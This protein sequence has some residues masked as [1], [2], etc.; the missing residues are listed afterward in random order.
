MTTSTLAFRRCL[1]SNHRELA[2]RRIKNQL[3]IHLDDEVV[4]HGRATLADEEDAQ[5]RVYV[6]RPI[7]SRRPG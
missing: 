5:K 7:P 2:G 6:E 1:P 3:D 4:W